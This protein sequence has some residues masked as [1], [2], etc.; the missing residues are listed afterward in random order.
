MSDRAMKDSGIEWIG[1]I[2]E[3]WE[4]KRLK[5]VCRLKSGHTPSRSEPSYWVSEE[6][7][8][9]WVSLNDTKTL[10]KYDYISDTAVKISLKGMSNSSAHLLD[11]VLIH[12]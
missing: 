8:I 12:F 5:F 10:K 1:E 11:T 4:V 7:V 9:P 6:C 2:P 3:H